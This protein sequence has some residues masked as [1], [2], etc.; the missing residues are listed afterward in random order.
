MRK[1]YLDVSDMEFQ[2]GGPFTPRMDSKGEQQRRDRDSGRP[3]WAVNLVVWSG[4]GDERRADTILVTVASDNPPTFD[5]MDFVNVKGLEIVPWVPQ[6]GST[7][8]RIAYRA[9]SVTVQTGSKSADT[10]KPVK[11]AS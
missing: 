9:E 11:V 5:Q 6:G 2:A 3:L 8:V 4:D 1:F 10:G 7:T